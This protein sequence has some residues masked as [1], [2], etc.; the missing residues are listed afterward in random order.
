M[1]S[2]N[3]DGEG[4]FS[5]GLPLDVIE[6]WIYLFSTYFSFSNNSFGSIRW[7]IF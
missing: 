7:R 1:M 5:K 3:S 4:T 6:Y 2:G